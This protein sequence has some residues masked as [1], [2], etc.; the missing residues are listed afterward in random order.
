M[1]IFRY[2][3]GHLAVRK[4]NTKGDDDFQLF[5]GHLAVTPEPLYFLNRK[6][7]LMSD[8]IFERLPKQD[9]PKM[10][11]RASETA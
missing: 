8:I 2:F 6:L 3:L 7:P 11:L 5:L 10:M 4:L 1:L 9:F